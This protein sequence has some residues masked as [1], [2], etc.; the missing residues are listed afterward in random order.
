MTDLRQTWQEFFDAELADLTVEDELMGSLAGD[1]TRSV[2]S[3]V[4]RLLS[5]Q[6]VVIDL[7]DVSLS[8]VNEWC[9]KADHRRVPPDRSC[10]T[11]CQSPEHDETDPR[12]VSA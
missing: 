1:S 9:W 7:Y 4:H 3:H 6:G 8:P 11:C 10:T 2:L 12:Q 5:E